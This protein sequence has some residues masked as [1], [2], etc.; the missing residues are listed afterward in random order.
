[1]PRAFLALLS[2][3]VVFN[4]ASGQQAATIRSTVIAL[5][6][7]Q[8]LRISLE[9]ELAEIARDHQYDAVAS[10]EIVPDI[11]DVG[12]RR[13]VS[14]LEFEG[15]QAVLML[16]PA[17]V[18]AGKSLESVRNEVTPG[19]YADI[20]AFAGELS[21][22]GSDDLISVIH[23]AIYTL[24]DGEARL[25]SSGAVWLEEPVA[26]REEGIQRLKDLIVANVDAAR[27]A[28]RSRL[29]LPPL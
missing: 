25:V 16:H 15:V 21:D 12:R 27:P 9:D 28:I 26:N 1:M 20:R 18:G 19:I 7:D 10:Y 8:Q 22:S 4:V 29:G 17:S 5:V 11:R 14:R 3:I 6:D 24:S 2:V 23:M 13:L